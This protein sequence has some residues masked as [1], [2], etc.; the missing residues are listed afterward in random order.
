[1]Q[2]LLW[3]ELLLAQY[4]GQKKERAL[5][6]SFC[7]NM[8]LSFVIA[9]V[10][11]LVCVL[12]PTKIM[13]LYAN[14][15]ETRANAAAYLK[16][17]AYSLIPMA[18]TS[19][20]SV[21]LHCVEKAYLPLI[22][23]ILSVVLNTVLNYVL[24]FGKCGFS[25][26]GVRG[27][28]IASVSA[29]IGACVLTLLFF[30]GRLA[31]V[32]GQIR[33]S[34]K[35]DRQSTGQYVRILA[36]VLICEFLWSA[37]E[38]VYAA[39]YGNIGTDACAAMTMTG[40][41]QGI[42]IG[43]LSGLSQAAGILIGKSL[44]NREYDKA[45]RDSARLMQYGILGAVFLSLA[46][47]FISPGYVLIYNVSGLVRGICVRILMVYAF[48]APVKV[49]NMILGGGIIRS[50]GRTGYVMWIDMIGTWIFGVPLG[51]LAAFVLH[52]PIQY[53]YFMLSVEEVVRLLISFVIFRR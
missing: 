11:T 20:V 6:S 51:L 2:C 32:K 39:I 35:S 18:V 28:A 15:M 36:P 48:I 43:V 24:I 29:Q 3:Q 10:F 26:M 9:A 37:G 1:M 4:I 22:A 23:G 45:Y 34:L 14:D 19:I 53:V 7:R 38:N 50:G 40:S 33:F 12:F 46:L 42:M 49:C 31:K 25:P 30:F 17:Y 47:V 8:L 5:G 44:G 52:L 13:S 21:L 16:I 27:A 41:V